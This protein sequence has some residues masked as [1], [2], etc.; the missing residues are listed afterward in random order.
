M[1]ILYN[2][3]H[4]LQ[5]I[6]YITITIGDKSGVRSDMFDLS[7][8]QRKSVR[9]HL[10]LPKVTSWIMQCINEANFAPEAKAAYQKLLND[11][12][13]TSEEWTATS[14]DFYYQEVARIARA[15]AVPSLDDVQRLKSLQ[16]F[17]SL[18]T[19]TSEE[20]EGSSS[21]SSTSIEMKQSILEKVNL[22]LLGDKYVKAVTEA[23][24]PT[25]TN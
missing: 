15:R 22:E 20:D 18:S 3:Y 10:A 16:A 8:E 11:Y 6:V 5:Y 24:T 14:I 23:M 9:K 12:G 2:R 17:L 25:G 4:N 1:D 21:S 13:V 19:T 7:E